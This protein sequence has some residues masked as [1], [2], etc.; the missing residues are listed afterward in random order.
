MEY[1]LHIVVMACLYVMLAL[2]LNLVMGYGGLL[3]LCQAGFY[4]AGAYAVALLTLKLHMGFFLAL[5]ICIAAA[6]LLSLLVGAPSLR[7]KGDYFVLASL[8]FQVIIF[9]VIYNWESLTGGPYGLPGIPRPQ[10]FGV[11]SSSLPIFAALV[12]ASTALFVLTMRMIALSPF[13]RMLKAI[14]EDET[15][16]AA[17][18]KSVPQAKAI[19]FAASAGLAAIPGAFFAVYARYID[20]TS[21]GLSE[22]IFIVTV[23]AVGGTGNLVGPTA[24][25]LLMIMLPEG[26]RLLHI[27]DAVAANARQ[28]VLGLVLILLMRV[29]PQGILG[30]YRFD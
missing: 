4:A 9:T 21:F 6:M 20:P 17:L 11:D 1:L 23:V 12:V 3:S 14:R 29:R 18:G 15:A 27:P 22:A 2:S 16:A 30:R 28:I 8:G 25:A 5:P 19:A 7:L 13:G 10:A 26:L 24:G